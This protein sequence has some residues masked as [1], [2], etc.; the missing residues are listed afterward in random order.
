MPYRNLLDLEFWKFE[1]RNRYNPNVVSGISESDP[2]EKLLNDIGTRFVKLD[3]AILADRIIVTP[4]KDSH[5]LRNPHSFRDI[6][7]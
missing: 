3:I 4:F 1:T 2:T 5:F 6:S 7:T